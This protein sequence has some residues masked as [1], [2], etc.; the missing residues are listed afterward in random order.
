MMENPTAV[1]LDYSFMELTTLDGDAKWG[2]DFLLNASFS[3]LLEEEPF[4]G[5]RKP[6][7]EIEVDA[8]AVAA[9]GGAAA[10]SADVEKEKVLFSMPFCRFSKG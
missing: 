4:A 6:R 2:L 3:E 7:Q 8:A 1:P 10:V 5:V 9:E